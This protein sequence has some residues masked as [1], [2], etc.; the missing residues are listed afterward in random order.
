MNPEINILN[1]T[2]IKK[3]FE[4]LN[5]NYGIELKSLP[6]NSKLI[7]RGKEKISIF[8][9]EI[10]DK[11][12]QK[13]KQFAS[14]ELI[15]LYFSKISS[16]ELDLKVIIDRNEEIKIPVCTYVT[17]KRSRAVLKREVDKVRKKFNKALEDISEKHSIDF[18][19][20]PEF[21]SV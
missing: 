6:K 10:S 1:N 3:I 9:G 7:Q 17:T 19:D 13:L 5:D 18:G 8:T 2:E 4:K 15:W 14:I 21:G 16:P 12:I 20:I 11:D